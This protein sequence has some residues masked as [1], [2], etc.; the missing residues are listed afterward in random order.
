MEH[1]NSDSKRKSTSR[2]NEEP[3]D[4]KQ[5]HDVSNGDL[6]P[7]S[8]EQ[9]EKSSCDSSEKLIPQENNSNEATAS[10]E[11]INS[12]STH[13]DSIEDIQ[14]SHD[15]KLADVSTA[16]QPPLSSCSSVEEIMGIRLSSVVS[17][18]EST[19][20][21]SSKD[22]KIDGDK[23]KW[24]CNRHFSDHGTNSIDTRTLITPIVT[25][26]DPQTSTTLFTPLRNKCVYGSECY[27]KNSEHKSKFSHPG[28][29]DYDIKDDRP[30]CRYGI[31]CYRKDSKHNQDFKHTKVRYQRVQTP[32]VMTIQDAYESGTDNSSVEESVD[33][34]EY[35]PSSIEYS[36]DNDGNNDW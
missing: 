27:R 15:K 16:S 29:S 2:S 9:I 13:G 4:K 14:I 24:Q 18:D 21:G 34:S 17:T 11:L 22:E 8:K 25:T 32:I 31:K 5:R 28:D 23:I 7:S 26:E 20:N 36:S 10:N 1:K 6:S 33:E 3:P 30:E 35:E 19:T 12:S